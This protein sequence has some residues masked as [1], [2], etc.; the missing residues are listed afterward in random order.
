[1]WAL[2][3][4]AAAVGGGRHAQTS[5]QF[6]A[7]TELVEVYATVVDAGGEAV[8][9]LPAE[10]FTVFEEGAPQP[11]AAFTAGEFPLTVAIAVDRSF[12]MT[13]RGLQTAGAGAL[14]LLDQL[15]A[16]DRVRI[17]AIGGRT[18]VLAGPDMPREQARQ[19]LTRVTL[20]G[21]SP[22][23]DTV[24]EAVSA[25]ATDPGRR[26]VVLLSDGVEREAQRPRHDVLEQVRQSGVLV[27]PIAIART[28]SP[29]LAELAALSGGRVLQ[30][31]DRRAAERAAMTI[32]R[33]LR[34]QYLLGYA[35]PPGPAGWRR[36]EVRVNRPG[37][38]VRA[39]QGYQAASTAPP[40]AR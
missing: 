27:Y 25:V 40:A 18:E 33:E 10:A 37:L 28:T 7:S 5:A 38:R 39:R 24:A 26:A 17:L 16:R 23:G 9:G 20:W 3:V 1:M 30:A 4:L 31:R 36:I 22:I 2:A 12:S 6:A 19:A 11:V 34:H 15:R 13:E 35:P 32:A 14:R 8:A 29:L 21:S